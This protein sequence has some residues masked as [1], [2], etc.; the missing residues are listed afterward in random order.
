MKIDQTR[1]GSVG[2]VAP[3][4]FITTVE[5]D[6]FLGVLGSSCRAANGRVILDFANVPYVDSSALEVMLE[7]AEV[8]RS[9][10]Q[11]AKLASVTE[12]CREILDLTDLLGEFEVYDSVDSAVRS[13]L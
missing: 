10:G 6:E 12:T 2:V 8:Q 4:G 11:A 9:A 1:V 7:F 3:R 13:F 5:K